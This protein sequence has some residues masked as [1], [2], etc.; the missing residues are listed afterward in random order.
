MSCVYVCPAGAVKT[1]DMEFSR[2]LESWKTELPLAK[3]MKCGKFFAP[4]PQ[5][6][7]PRKKL[8]VQ[9]DVLYTCPACKRKSYAGK[10]ISVAKFHGG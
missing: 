10:L 6:E 4:L 7:H 2:K 1:E 9:D 3:C 8:N 5:L